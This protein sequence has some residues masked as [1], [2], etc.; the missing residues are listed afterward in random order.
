MLEVIREVLQR[1]REAQ[2]QMRIDKCKF[3]CREVDF[4]G[5][6]ISGDGVAPIADNV[7]AILDFPEPTNLSELERFIE[8]ANYYRE[9]IQH[10]A[11]IAEPSTG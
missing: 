5:H 9:F 11:R 7:K 4:V 1:F 10:F 3:A 6:H 8:M 2:L